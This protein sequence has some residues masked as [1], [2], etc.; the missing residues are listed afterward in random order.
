LRGRLHARAEYIRVRIR[1]ANALERGWYV[2]GAYMVR[3][4][5][6]QLVARVE[7]YD[8]RD[9]IATDR[10]T[11]YSLGGQYFFKGDA[12]KL[13]ADYEAFR[14]QVTQLKN[15]R[16]VVQMQVRW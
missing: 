7:Q 11:G 4:S 1:P 5:R 6:F 12:L 9:N 10:V 8:P 16:A 13:M 14:E 15:D 2:L 3:P